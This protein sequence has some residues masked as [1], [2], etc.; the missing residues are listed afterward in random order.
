MQ[1]DLYIY[2]ELLMQYQ[3]ISREIHITLL[4]FISANTASGYPQ[5]DKHCKML[6]T[7]CPAGIISEY[8]STEKTALT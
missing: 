6:V 5:V 7:T 1:G 2:N 4:Y 3:C 8:F